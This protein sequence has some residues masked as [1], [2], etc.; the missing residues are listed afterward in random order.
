MVEGV[1]DE[2]A[3]VGPGELWAARPIVSRLAWA[4]GRVVEGVVDEPA[5]VGPGE[6]LGLPAEWPGPGDPF[7]F[8]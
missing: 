5:E 1:V 8:D 4:T 6:L 7:P 3:E 2:P